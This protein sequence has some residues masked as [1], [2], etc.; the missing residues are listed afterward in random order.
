MTF[1]AGLFADG[2]AL[3]E[4]VLGFAASLAVS[5]DEL[6]EGIKYPSLAGRVRETPEI[7][8]L[9]EEVLGFI[10]SLAVSADELAEGM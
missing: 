2:E 4:E 8:A 6:A 3:A 1:V 5:A 9:A 10:A 7:E